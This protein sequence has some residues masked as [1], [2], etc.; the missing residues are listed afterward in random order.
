[1]LPPVA[2]APCLWAGGQLGPGWLPSVHY[3][4]RGLYT[5]LGTDHQSRE[6]PWNTI[7][8]KLLRSDRMFFS[9]SVSFIPYQATQKLFLDRISWCFT[10]LT[11][12]TST[13]PDIH[14]KPAPYADTS[15]FVAAM[16]TALDLIGPLT[17]FTDDAQQATTIDRCDGVAARRTKDY[18]NHIRAVINALIGHALSF[19]N[20]AQPD[21]RRPLSTVCQSLLRECMAFEQRMASSMRSDDDSQCQLSAT[22]VEN[23]LY[24]LD[25]LVNDS[26]LR[27]VYA[28]FVEMAAKPLNVLAEMIECDADEAEVDNQIAHF[29][30]VADRLQQIGI[31]AAA[32]APNLSGLLVCFESICELVLLLLNPHQNKPPFGAPLPRLRL[33]NLRSYQRCSLATRSTMPR[34]SANTGPTSRHG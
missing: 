12:S 2:L 9:F 6:L 8:G 10:K 13:I 19:A 30:E 18:A 25:G 4:N 17:M 16:D 5:M 32:F 24:Q 11:E 33:W 34:C 31:F 1:M 28:V 3:P 14:I 29:D 20:L 23:A 22:R 27:L 21:D 26:L 7:G 15:N